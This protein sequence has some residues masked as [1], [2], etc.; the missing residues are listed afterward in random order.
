MLGTRPGFSPRRCYV[1]SSNR[2]ELFLTNKSA[3]SS[4]KCGYHPKVKFAQTS[5]RKTNHSLHSEFK[6]AVIDTGASRSCIKLKQANAY[7]IGKGQVQF[8]RPSSFSFKFGDV[9]HKSRGI[10]TI[11]LPTP[12]GTGISFEC[13]VLS[14]NVPLLV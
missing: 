8:I 7:A 11:K 6:G 5:P 14:A 3:I 1:S 12:E 2:H 4:S 10:I 9:I 13:D